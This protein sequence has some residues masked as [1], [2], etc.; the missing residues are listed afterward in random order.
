M[1]FHALTEY[2]ALIRKPIRLALRSMRSET[3]SLEDWTLIAA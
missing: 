1:S 2:E 3:Y